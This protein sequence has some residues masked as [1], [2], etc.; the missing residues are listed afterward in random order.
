MYIED[1]V[2]EDYELSDPKTTVS[3]LVDRILVETRMY[4]CSYTSILI[5]LSD[6]IIL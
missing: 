4:I 2:S 1:I 3:K 5:L 6:V